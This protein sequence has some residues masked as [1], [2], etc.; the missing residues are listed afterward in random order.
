MGHRASLLRFDVALALCARKHRLTPLR[1]ETDKKRH[2]VI[3]P[4]SDVTTCENLV[5]NQSDAGYF[6]FVSFSVPPDQTLSCVTDTCREVTGSTLLAQTWEHKKANK[7]EILA[8][9]YVVSTSPLLMKR[10]CSCNTEEYFCFLSGCCCFGPC[11]AY[12][13]CYFL[14]WY[15]IS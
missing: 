5:T 11:R 15:Y 14:C 10:Q 2:K 9:V 3:F 7:K 8:L 1:S 13:I 6:E 4:H 12:S